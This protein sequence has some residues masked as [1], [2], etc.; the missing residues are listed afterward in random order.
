MDAVDARSARST[1]NGL[2]EALDAFISYRRAE[3]DQVAPIAAAIEA[4][5]RDIWLDTVDIPAGTLW[6]TELTR[7]IEVSAAVVCFVSPSWLESAECRR[8]LDYAVG[9]HKR[10]LPVQLSDV[11]GHDIIDALHDIQWIDARGRAPQ[12]VAAQI[13]AA[14]DVDA[15]WFRDHTYWLG[16]AIRWN[17][18]GRD[19][20]LLV[21]G[22]DLRAAE[23]WLERPERDPRPNELQQ[24]FVRAS[25]R[26]ERRR[27]KPCSRSHPW[28]PSSR[29]RWPPSPGISA[30]LPL[31]SG[32]Q[33]IPGR[34]PHRRSKSWTPTGIIRCVVSGRVA[35]LADRA[36]AHCLAAFLDRVRVRRTIVSGSSSVSRVRLTRDGNR[37]LGEPGRPPAGVG[38][39]DRPAARRNV[40]QRPLQLAVVGCGRHEGLSWDQ[41]GHAVFGRSTRAATNSPGI[42]LR[43]GD[44]RCGQCRWASG[45]GGP[46]GDGSVLTI[47]DGVVAR[48]QVAGDEFPVTIAI[49]DGGQSV[50]I[51]TQLRSYE[52]K[53]L[54]PPVRGRPAGHHTLHCRRT[55]A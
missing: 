34:W 15:E 12:Q 44:G 42:D 29:S 25:R 23:E 54:P 28:S 52:E 39:R 20:S 43:R 33:P 4:T 30:R 22:K 6:R 26:G 7:A 37:D 14:I 11:T 13:I 50:A 45:R 46:P 19:R 3:S 8:E 38:S 10:L 2:P 55:T 18:D 41:A 35:D 16:R 51:G 48:S 31:N 40:R 36:G 47:V 27:C 1:D 9:L 53:T 17:E 21:R 24:D 49:S 32:I 5:G